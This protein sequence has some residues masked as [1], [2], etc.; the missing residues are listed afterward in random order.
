MFFKERNKALNAITA[1]KV[2]RVRLFNSRDSLFPLS[3]GF[4]VLRTVSSAFLSSS[5]TKICK[6]VQGKSYWELVELVNCG[7]GFNWEHFGE[8]LFNLYKHFHRLWLVEL[9]L[10]GW[11][12]HQPKSRPGSPS[13]RYNIVYLILLQ[14]R[15][16]LSP[17]ISNPVDAVSSGWFKLVY[18]I[19]TQSAA[20]EYR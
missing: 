19:N 10:P 7:W 9:T 15:T 20:N 11:R 2:Y 18:K 8:C 4:Q 16:P 12:P 3:R 14:I 1:G 5:E 13:E 6:L 17:R